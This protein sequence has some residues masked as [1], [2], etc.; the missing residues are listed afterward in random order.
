MQHF[1][2][3]GW[4]AGFLL[5]TVD[6]SA[7]AQSPASD[8]AANALKSSTSMRWRP[9]SEVVPPWKR[10]AIPL[11]KPSVP[12][13][14]MGMAAPRLKISNWLRGE[15]VKDFA[16][17]H[18]YVVTF[19]TSDSDVCRESLPYLEK[20]HRQFADR[21]VIVIALN[22]W[23]EDPHRAASVMKHIGGDLTM[24]VATDDR[25]ATMSRTWIGAMD[26]PYVPMAFVIDR[27][28]RIAWVGHTSKLD[29]AILSAV[30]AD[31]FDTQR[32]IVDRN[33]RRRFAEAARRHAHKA[34]EARKRRD[35][36]A[37]EKHLD[38]FERE[39]PA[40]FRFSAVH[41]RFQLAAERKDGPAVNRFALQLSEDP[42][43]AERLND[44]AWDMALMEDI[45]GLDLQFAERLARRELERSKGV[46]RAHVL[47]TLA[48]IQFRLGR[49]ID[50]IATQKAAVECC[51]EQDRI[52]FQSTLTSYE[53]GLLPD[54]SE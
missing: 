12:P 19:W 3:F 28:Q 49:Q 45:E 34:I 52:S 20:L 2:A 50:A 18:V 47:D 40:R 22:C 9:L 5:L 4:L 17:D 54:A 48:R 25:R 42:G 37:A 7:T 36:A 46:D 35:W 10:T 29:D 23:D 8:A 53:K 33:E 39:S 1:R 43:M 38:E 27:H 44:I 26:E 32:A 11:P 6:I 31:K 21:G 51:D 15:P 16:V 13:L 30:L 41:Q 14:D 24:R